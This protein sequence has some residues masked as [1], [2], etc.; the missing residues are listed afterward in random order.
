MKA[1]FCTDGSELS[2]NALTNL[3][4]YCDDIEIDVFC[5]IDWHFHPVYMSH[6][7]QDFINTYDDIANNVLELAVEYIKEKGFAVGVLKKAWGSA[8]EEILKQTQKTHYDLIILGSHGKKGVK[9]WLG[10]VSRR[11]ANIANEPVFISKE[12]KENKRILLTADGSFCSKYA[13]KKALSLLNL[14]DKEIFIITVMEDISNLPI[15]I[16]SNKEWFNDYLKKRNCFAQNVIRET[17]ATLKDFNLTASKDFS[18]IGAPSTTILE[19]IDENNIDLVILGSRSKDR[20]SEFLLGSTSKRV[21][22][23]ANCSVL[24]IAPQEN[25]TH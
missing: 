23:H 19:A 17:Y 4:K 25:E 16:T 22:E 20:I 15:E 2:L 12:L 18:L 5:V 7:Q 13:I 21:L 6:P 8:S 10:S 3:Q 9:S 24:I 11:V 14:Q 1:L